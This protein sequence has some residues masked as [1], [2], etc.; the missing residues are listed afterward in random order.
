V[1]W[2]DKVLVGSKT[3]TLYVLSTKVSR[4]ARPTSELLKISGRGAEAKVTARL[5]LTG[6]LGMTAALDESAAAPALWLGGAG[7][8][9]RLE[10]RGAG[11]SIAGQDAKEKGKFNSLLNPNKDHI[12]FVCFGDVDA[13]A[14]LVYITSGMGP[15]WRY[16]GETGEGGLM[17]FKACDVAIGPGGMIYGWGNP[18]GYKGPVARYTRDGKPAPLANGKNTYGNVFGRYG[19]GNNAAGMAVDN[20]GWVY[21]TCGFND[22]HV[23]VYN[24]EGNLVPYER[25]IT[26]GKE[27]VPVL[28]SYV[29][30]QGGNIRVDNSYNAYVLEIGLPKGFTPPKRCGKEPAYTQSTGTIYKFTPKGGEFKK[31]TT[32]WEAVGA[33]KTYAGCGPV[34]GSWN[35]TQSVCHC[36]RPRYNLDAYGRLYIP[37]GVT[38]KVSVRD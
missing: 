12:S 17:P 32:G 30:D 18:G 13:E 19:R 26:V 15:V 29:L 3:G 34:S 35:S 20:R 6:S 10:D 1:P 31:G 4:G 27:E 11:F 25:K 23:R 36:M 28:I 14:E 7:E 24:A 16:H 33:V 5:A 37:H 8:V 22:C 21:A 2:P 38:Y 9:V